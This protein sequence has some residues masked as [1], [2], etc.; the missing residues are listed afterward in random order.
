[1]RR[2]EAL[3]HFRQNNVEPQIKQSLADLDAYYQDNWEE[4]TGSL[5]AAF[6]ALCHKTAQAQSAGRK[7]GIA[8]I[9][10]S[11]LYTSLCRGQ[12]VCRLDAYDQNWFLDKAEC[13]VLY[14]AGWA[15]SFLHEAC[16]RLAQESKKYI[17]RITRYDIEL[18][19]RAEAG[20][21][22]E[23]IEDLGK[24]VMEDV[25]ATAEFQA[26]E[27]ADELTVYIGEYKDLCRKTGAYHR[28]LG[29]IALD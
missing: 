6:I 15:F 23:Y 1:M 20:R 17:G 10:G 24:E 25:F 18:I 9:Y 22:S 16:S 19:K 27:K 28:E 14:D 26:L 13:S 29:P 11:F 21:Y 8:Y 7:N 5:K 12:S 4:L 3:R 2:D